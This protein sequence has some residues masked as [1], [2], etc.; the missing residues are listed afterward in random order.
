M[1]LRREQVIDALTKARAAAPPRGFEQSVELIVNLKDIDFKK[2]EKRINLRVEVPN[3][4]GGRKVLIFASGDLALRARRAGAD[5][6]IE[7]SEL[8]AM[9]KDKKEMKRR[10]KE[11]DI[12]YAEATLMPLVGRLVGPFLGPRGR[13]PT[14]IP[15]TTPVEGLIEAG[16]RTV[17][18]RSRDK[19]LIQCA[20][21]SEKMED[22]KIAENIEA[23]LSSL[24]PVLDRGYGNIRSAY[25]KLTMGPAVR[26]M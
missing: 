18:L 2:P 17:F 5:A 10:L 13:M 21:G 22:S 3:G 23:V 1:S 7:P 26:L 24:T 4:F 25:V 15:P 20:V 12:F 19:P 11:F 14:P 8:E 6:V 9:A 16:R